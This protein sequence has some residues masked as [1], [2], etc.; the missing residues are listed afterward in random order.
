MDDELNILPISSTI[1][2]I[3]P[4]SQQTSVDRQMTEELEKL[5][6]QLKSSELVGPLVGLCKT[7]DQAKSVMSLIDCVTEKS[8]RYTVSLTAGRGRGKSAAVGMSIA[9][10][11]AAGFSN[12]FVT[13]P[14]P[15]NLKTLFDFILEGLRALDYKENLHFEVIQSTNPEFNNSVI[16]VNINKTHRQII[17]YILPVDYQ[18]IQN[19]DLLVIDEA[20]AIPL[21]YVQKLMGPYLVFLSSTVNGY[22]GTGRSLSLKLIKQIKQQNRVTQDQNTCKIDNSTREFDCFIPSPSPPHI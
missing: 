15:D 6:E 22:E 10:A 13:A 8:L 21:T 2:S 11:V 20:A 5:K 12:I 3:V 9:G 18:H 16:R 17:Q 1:D 4:Q 7:L 14:S 19:A